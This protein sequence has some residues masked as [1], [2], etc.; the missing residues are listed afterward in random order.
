MTVAEDIAPAPTPRTGPIW[1]AAFIGLVVCTNIA[2]ASWV[3]MDDEH[4]ASLLLLSSRNRF[5]VATVPSGISPVT[6][7][8][9]ACARIGA[10]A[11]VCHMLGRAYGDRAL[12]WFWRFLGMPPEQVTKF[13]NAFANAEW[14]VVPFFVGSNIVWVLSG[15]AKT[16]W[17]RLLPLAAVGLAIRL[18]LL[19]WLSKQFESEVRST[20]KWF[21]Q[22][23]WW[24]LIGSVLI[25]LL[26][27]VRNFR[28]K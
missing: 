27:N 15:A 16:T 3:T 21:D 9:I 19:W 25:V 22:Y 13:E 8:L 26:V 20:L 23:Q 11:I 10:S 28:G 12:R 2:T 1:V 18:A 14:A 6:W 5:L 17:K 4:P 24:I 7:A